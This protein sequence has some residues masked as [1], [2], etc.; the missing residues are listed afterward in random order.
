MPSSIILE[1]KPIHLAEL[2]ERLDKIETRDKELGFRATKTKDYLKKFSK[3]DNKKSTELIAE[4]QKL[5][6][7]RIRDRQIVKIVDLLPI[8]IDE[9]RMIFVGE[10]TTITPENMQQILNV[11]KKYA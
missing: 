1:E 3:L 10:I 5:N 9:L 4:I 6:I 8:S 7:P 11:V 2:K